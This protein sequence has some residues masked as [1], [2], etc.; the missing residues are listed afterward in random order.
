M[1]PSSILAALLLAMPPLAASAEIVKW[2]DDKGQ[3]HYSDQA[4]PQAKKAKTL[5]L[6]AAPSAPPPPP[7]EAKSTA[8]KERDF[9]QRRMDA[10]A[11]EKK[12]AEAQKQAEQDRR[13]CA[14]ARSNLQSLESGRVVRY[15]E[16]GEKVFLDDAQRAA[17]MEQARKDISQWCK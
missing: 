1:K 4:P 12:A 14:A 17:A 2:V 5:N 7:A 6:P 9:Q 11:A 15:D 16:N 13:N 8:E 3:V 10:E